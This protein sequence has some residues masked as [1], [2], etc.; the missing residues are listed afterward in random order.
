LRWWWFGP[1][2][3]RDELTRELTAMADAGFG[4]VEVAYV[5]PLGPATTAFMSDAF[6]AHL[7]F[8]AD[9]AREL[10]LRFDLT[11]GSGWSF[12]GPHITDEL[13]AR[14][15]HWE[16]SEI[17]PGPLEIP[18]VSPWPGDQLV[19]AYIG[20]GSI[21][22][23]P[24]SYHQLP[25]V[26]DMIKIPDGDGTRQVL[27]AYARRTGQN[28]KRAA[29]GSEG[30]VLDH[31]SAA[32]VKAHLRWAGDRMLDAVPADLV[33]SVF[34]DSLE[35]YEADWTLVLPEEFAR[36]CGYPLVPVLYR[37]AVDG[38][39]AARVRADYHRTLVEL[40]QENF[41][42]VVQR[43]AASRGVPFRIQSY[44]TPPATISSYRFADMFEGEGWGWKEITQTRWAS[45]AGHIYGRDVVSAEIWTWVH[46][47]SFRATPLD[48]KGEAHEHLLNGIN[49]LVG[50]GWPY[51]PADAPGLGWFFYASGA[52]D[53]RNPWWPVMARL[54]AYLSRLCWLLRQGEPVADVAIYVPNEDLFA[55]MGREVGGSLDTWREASRRIA[56]EIPATI[57]LAGLDYDLID[58]E[59]LAITPPDRYR[60]VI[61]PATTMI[62]DATA[63][64]LTKVP[65]AGGS[66]IMINST[67]QVPG[68]VTAVGP[69]LADE[70][71]A[72]VDPDLEITPRTADIGFV[73]RR[74]AAADIYLLANTGPQYRT[75]RITARGNSG[76]YEEWDATSGKV[77]RAGPAADGIEVA[78]H[79]YQ[80]TVIIMIG[81]EPAGQAER[82][83]LPDPT[84][85]EQLRRLHLGEPWQVAFGDEP[86]QPVHLPHVWEDQPDRRHYSGS[87]TYTTTC[88]LGDFRT[89][90]IGVIDF[91]D[92]SA[93]DAPVAG[94]G[95]DLVG[96][97]YRV[98]VTGPVGEIAQVRVNGIDCGIAWAP[99]YRIDITDAARSGRNDIEIT[100]SNT[101]A[102]A[103]AADQHIIELAAQSEA[104][105]GRRF[106]MQDL[107]RAMESVR[108]GLLGVPTIVLSSSG[109]QN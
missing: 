34:C 65:A 89:G 100:V 68:A 84:A 97:S 61:V 54:N 102:N 41:V 45:S 8:A 75:F 52:I 13:A 2:V 90:T 3:D 80:A 74:S 11:L 69:D 106:R 20:A 49:Q 9:R 47:P 59:A 67:V 1:S 96:P 12:G 104:R 42:A 101:A 10:G 18:V 60:V 70:L 25:V 22:E 107:D 30:P 4:G 7:R 33:G 93:I 29:V 66:V 91:G 73:H 15:L 85:A 44:G 14:R 26:D 53:D 24:E 78:L 56:A 72:A 5:Y 108:S 17:S 16:R 46:S 92:C 58:D 35:V 43:W 109:A 95:A 83:R 36:R 98:G 28:V 94:N 27:L 71:A 77:V 99:P 64:W 105:Y 76:G 55:V 86:A 38:P 40:F 31:Y 82:Y 32:A 88:D 51:S 6:L 23:Q 37:L 57:R 87:A 62:V 50:H 79:P 39:G 21:Q 81:G 103:L 48:L 19:A 63:T